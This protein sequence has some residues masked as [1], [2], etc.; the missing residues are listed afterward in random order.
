MKG[1]PKADKQRLLAEQ[2]PRNT[3]FTMQL[4]YLTRPDSTMY[5]KVEADTTQAMCRALKTV[6]R[7]SVTY[8][9]A[10]NNPEATKPQYLVSAKLHEMMMIRGL[11]GAVKM[12]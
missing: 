9:P 11:E 3:L 2:L 1:D 10:G 5:T 8:K 6:H 7:M 4:L 12:A